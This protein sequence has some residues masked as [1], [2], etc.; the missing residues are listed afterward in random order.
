MKENKAIP[1]GGG[2]FTLDYLSI[3]TG[4]RKAAYGA[5]QLLRAPPDAGADRWG[6]GLLGEGSAK[7]EE[8]RGEME[9]AAL[10]YADV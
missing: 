6:D 9:I 4:K 3:E 10:F 5:F 8:A 7:I 1:G 2:F